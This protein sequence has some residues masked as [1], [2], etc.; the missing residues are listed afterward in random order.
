MYGP[1]GPNAV[2][3]TA[4]HELLPESRRKVLAFADSRQEAVLFAWYAEDSCGKLRDRNLILRA[5]MSEP[6]AEEGLSI[7]DLRDRLL[8]EWDAAGPF[9]EADT[10]EQRTRRVLTS[11]LREAMTDEKRLSL[12]GVGLVRWFVA[13][14]R[15]LRLPN[16]MLRPPWN[17]TEI[18]ARVLADYL[19]DEMCPRHRPSRRRR[20]TGMERFLPPAV[21]RLSISTISAYR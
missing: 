14:P 7:D 5:I 21:D 11:I 18:E 20:N 1:D 19:L 13:R 17:L 3:A 15:D 2:V 4:L 9:S 12:A 10:R 16:A 8:R 6:I